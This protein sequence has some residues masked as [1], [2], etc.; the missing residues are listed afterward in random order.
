MVTLP[1]DLRLA[2]RTL[3]RTPGV[4][5]LA[6]ASLGLAIGFSTAAFSILDAFS[7]RELA[8]REPDRLVR[9]GV[10]TR[11]GRGDAVSWIEYQALAARVREFAG[12]AV[13][14]R[15]GVPV[16]LPGR[17]DHP[18]M[19]YVSDN[20]FDVL[21]VKAALGDVF[22]DGQGQDATAVITHRYW[23]E[24]LGGDPA[25]V[26]RTLTVGDSALVPLRIVGVLPPAF[27]GA[28]RGL[29]VDFFLPPQTVFGA[30]RSTAGTDLKYT[31]YELIGRLR[32]GATADDARQEGDAVLRQIESDGRA[33]A[34]QRRFYLSAFTEGLGKK[35]ASNATMLGI[36]VLLVLIAATNLANLRLVDNESRRHETGVRLALGAGRWDLARMHLTETF[37]LASASTLL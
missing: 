30:L 22:H 19:G 14:D 18:I 21:G 10:T 4:A 23:Q 32:P 6:L 5:A 8:V 15:E 33:P 1:R 24:T 25:I 12:L 28:Q 13:E 35:L 7:L 20:Y 17:N 34:P 37:V 2:V 16:H 11:E 27:T 29:M 26:G 9:G 36:I 31:S 3:L